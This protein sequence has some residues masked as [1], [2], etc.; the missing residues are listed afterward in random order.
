MGTEPK[1]SMRYFLAFAFLFIWQNQADAQRVRRLLLFAA[2]STV[3]EVKIQREWLEAVPEE[4]EDRDIWIAVFDDPKTFRRMYEHYEVGRV[5][6]HLVLVGKDFTVKFRSDE[7]VPAEK[8][9]EVIDAMPMRQEEI[10][11]RQAGN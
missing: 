9:F 10:K 2:D 4:V 7:P 8:L 6:F 3:A 11:Q 1:I 5:D